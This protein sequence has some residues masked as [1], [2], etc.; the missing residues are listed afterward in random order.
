MP[1][2]SAV[3]VHFNHL[4][5][6]SVRM[7]NKRLCFGGILEDDEDATVGATKTAHIS[8]TKTH[9]DRS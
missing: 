6:G 7:G 2:N 1:D 8:L 4:H 5:L 3:D 9:S